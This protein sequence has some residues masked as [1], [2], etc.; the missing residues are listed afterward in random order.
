MEVIRGLRAIALAESESKRKTP[1]ARGDANPDMDPALRLGGSADTFPPID[2]PFE[3][4]Y[5]LVE[6]DYV[7]AEGPLREAVNP[8][9]ENFAPLAPKV[10]APG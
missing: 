6:I 9:A 5:E 4:T 2:V 1:A 3:P 7:D 10:E 8:N